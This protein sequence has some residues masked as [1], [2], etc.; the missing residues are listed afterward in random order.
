MRVADVLSSECEFRASE[1]K[2]E[3]TAR[4]YQGAL[5]RPTADALHPNV[6]LFGGVESVPTVQSVFSSLPAHSALCVECLVKQTTL[7][8]REIEH[9]L[10]RLGANLSEG[11]CAGC[12]E[13]GPVFGLGTRAA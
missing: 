10:D 6:T 1:G 13:S 11:F 8:V 4:G 7:H 9:E 12:T 3:T 2:C 5:R